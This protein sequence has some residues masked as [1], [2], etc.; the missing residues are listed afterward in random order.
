MEFRK[1]NTFTIS[2]FTERLRLFTFTLR[3]AESCT[4][5]DVVET[6]LQLFTVNVDMLIEK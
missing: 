1:R 4:L 2:V 6:H 3:F 5:T